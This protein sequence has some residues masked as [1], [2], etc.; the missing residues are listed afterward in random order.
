MSAEFVA[1]ME[2]VLELAPEVREIVLRL[3]DPI[4]SKEFGIRALR[5][6][7][8]SADEQLQCLKPYREGIIAQWFAPCDEG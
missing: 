8:R 4:A 6:L 3:G 7:S 1:R 5:S 2:D